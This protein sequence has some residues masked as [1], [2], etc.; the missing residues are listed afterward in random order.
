MRRNVVY[1]LIYLLTGG[2]M[3]QLSLYLNDT[4]MQDLRTSA[5]NDGVSISRYARRVLCDDS[6]RNSWSA[7]FLSTFGAS[8]DESF[9][10]QDEIPW[11]LDT[12]RIEF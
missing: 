5:A 11:E 2:D 9:K 10:V 7:S 3:P 1:L 8:G 12:K 4:E 6:N